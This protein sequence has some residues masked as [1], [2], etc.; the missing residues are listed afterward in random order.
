MERP[1][2]SVLA[3]GVLALAWA[4]CCLWQWTHVL[5]YEHVEP[6]G[7]P[8]FLALF[9]GV[10]TVLVGLTYIGWTNAHAKKLASMVRRSFVCTT[11]LCALVLTGMIFSMGL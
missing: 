5:L 11:V 1:W 9:I 6:F 7:T 2:F 3:G 10:P 4:F 8:R